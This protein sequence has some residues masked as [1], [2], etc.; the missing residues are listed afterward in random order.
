MNK[1]WAYLILLTFSVFLNHELKSQNNLITISSTQ[2][3]Q[4]TVCGPSQVFT[5]TL[6]NSTPFLIKEDTLRIKMPSGIHYQSGSVTVAK[7]YNVSVPDFPVFTFPD[8]PSL[9]SVQIT[10]KAS[11]GCDALAYQAS[12]G[13]I[14]NTIKVNYLANTIPGYD[15]LVTFIYTVSQPNI[16]IVSVTNQSYSGNIGDVFTRCIT[17]TNGGFG[18]LGQFTLTDTHGSGVQITGVSLGQW[19]HSGSMETIVLNGSNFVKIGNGDSLFENGESITVCE[20]IKVTNCD[21]VASAF[22]AYWGCGG[23]NCQS[24][25]SSA[26]VVFPNLTPNLVITANG[27]NLNAPLNACFSQP[28]QQVLKIVNTGLG[29]AMNVQLAIFESSTTGYQ[30][31]LGTQLDTSSF[32]LQNGFSGL[33]SPVYPTG[34]KATNA[35]SCM[36]NPQGEV[37]LNIPPINPGDTLYLKWNTYSC[38]WNNCKHIGY[39]AIEGWNY[40]GS[41]ENICQTSYIIPETVG[42]A[43][44]DIYQQLDN[45]GSPSTLTNGQTGTFDFVFSTYA[46]SYPVG[47]GANWTYVFTLPPC[48]SYSGNLKIINFDGIRT[49][50]PSSVIVT[51]DSVI[52]VFNGKFPWNA[53]EGNITINLSA[54]CGGCGGG[55]GSVSLNSY[56]ISDTLASCRSVIGVSCQST[57]VSVICPLP[58]PQGMSFSYFEMKRSSYGLPDNEP[59]GGNGIPDP[60]PATLD[61]TKIR[62]DIAMFGD[63]ITDS[64]NGK[65]ITS[66]SYPSWQYCYANSS[67]TNGNYLSYLDDSLIVYRAGIAAVTCTNFAPT[68]TNAGTTRNF[69]F[70]LSISTL[71]ACFPIGFK[72]LNNDSLVFKPRYKVITNTGGPLL[73]CYSTNQYF[74]SD[75]PNPTLPANIF[76]CGNY[77]GDCA[78][79]GYYFD[80][81][82]QDKFSVTSCNNVTVSQRYYLSIGP[83]CTNYNG[84]NL[85]AYEYRNWAHIKILEAVVP[86][87]YSFVSAEF[88]QERTAGTTATNI[89]PWIPITPVNPNSN[90][91]TFDVEQYFQGYGG[92]LPLPDDGF[93]GY[94]NVTLE[95]SC[96]VIPTLYEPVIYNFTFSTDSTDFLSG[97]GSAPTFLS[98]NPDSITYISPVLL[99]Q[100]TLPSILATNNTATWDVSLGNTSGSSNALNGWL[101]GPQI[102]GVSIIQVY[103]L[104]NHVI[105]PSTGG[106]YQIG[107]VKAGTVR[108]FSLTAAY[109][110]CEQDSIIVYAG[111]NCASGYPASLSSYACKPQEITLKLSPLVP[112]LLVNAIGPSGTIQ[113]CDTAVYNVEGTNVQLGTAYQ[114]LL[115]ASLPVGVTIVPGSSRFSF[116]V[117]GPYV[118]IAD[119]LSAGGTRWNWNLSAINTFTDTNGLK[120]ILNP[121]LDSFKLS[122]KVITNCDYTSGSSI[123]FNLQ[124]TSTC[125]ISTGN[126]QFQ[127]TQLGITGATAT[128]STT[129][130]LNTNYISPC[131]ANSSMKISVINKGPMVFGANDSVVLEIPAGISFVP[132]S[133]SGL[134]NYPVNGVPVQFS[135]N[136]KNYVSWKIPAGVAAGDSTLFSFDYHG[137]VSKLSCDVSAFNSYSTS[138]KNITCV[139]S[140][141]NCGISVITGDTSLSVF[142]YKAYLSLS[143]GSG[144]SVPNPPAGEKIILNFDITNAG[145]SILQGA[146]SI[147]KFYNDVNGNGVYDPGDFFLTQDTLLV[148]N[149]SKVSSADTFNVP[150]GKGCSIIA[151]VDTSFNHCVCYLSQILIKPSYQDAGRDTGVCSGSAIDLG[152]P[153][154][155]G[156]TYNWMPLTGLNSGILSNPVLTTSNTS[157]QVDSILYLVRTNRIGCISNDSV[158]VKTFPLPTLTIAGLTN[159]SCLGQ[160]TGS[161]VAD[162]SG[163]TGNYS[164][165]WNTLPVQTTGTALN[166]TAGSYTCT[167]TDGKGCSAS[168]AVNITQPVAALVASDSASVNLLC[169]GTDNGSASIAVSGGNGNYSFSWNTLPVQ[170]S[171][172]ALNLAAGTYTCTVTDGKGCSAT[173]A[174]AISQPTALLTSILSF[175]NVTCAGDNNGSATA[176]ASGSNGPYGYT[177]SNGSSGPGISAVGVG[178]YTLTVTDA[179]GCTNSTSVSI[180]S[181]GPNVSILGKTNPCQGKMSG[182]ITIQATGIS[183]LS[184]HWNNGIGGLTTL[185]NLDSGYYSVTVTDLNGCTA[186]TSVN[187]LLLPDPPAHAGTSQTISLGHS[188]QLTAAGGLSYLWAPPYSLND[189]T[190]P[191][192]VASPLQTTIYR[193]TVTDMNDCSATDSVLI[194]V[195]NCDLSEWYVPSAFSPNGDGR[196]DI[197]YVRG[198]SVC[199]SNIEF[200]VY[201]RWGELVFFTS[202]MS[203]GWDGN[204]NGK[205]AETAAFIYYL[206]VHL[207]NGQTIQKKGNLTLLR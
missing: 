21:S 33:P 41:Y 159:V 181:T 141:K 194:T 90:T 167:V 14:E 23:Q 124:G 109:T 64:F 27:G 28:S 4:M 75:V 18:A 173:T 132:G 68:I 97:P 155:N 118:S 114:L 1:G 131:A 6:Y 185:S 195:V 127:S 53:Q 3:V 152:Y 47:P 81:Y 190:L 36:T 182:S 172:T 191:D 171:P 88:N 50:N 180:T 72:Y 66:L 9:T 108:N 99:L 163:G 83:C 128:Y 149:N 96:Q 44:S 57:S 61:F 176:N 10:F 193:V 35:Y 206:T 183:S 113:L 184:Y 200:S 45:N 202:N 164:Y 175:A 111:W 170:T 165:L 55:T 162:A 93:L 189:S 70:D 151:I 188:I 117:A 84:G 110:S 2:P 204:F 94:F 119:P 161:S 39:N 138:A 74:L 129:I 80:N 154:V 160:N 126:E 133:F 5:V 60:P 16:S 198:Q 19:N 122:F 38:T 135:L 106:I 20:T 49:L 196:N 78:V 76:Q 134:H 54:N 31:I 116:P 85:F 192:P 24:S 77:N 58:C 120:G 142:T 186:S 13:L 22:E 174:I 79:A 102:S 42:R 59:G 146:N 169:N 92:T 207:I 144:I 143:N 82:G 166:L 26:N 43:Y 11:A 87:G 12:G 69:N 123:G 89:S 101:S 177:W 91:L 37:F 140:G 130:H 56:Y 125:G 148:P 139:T 153:A 115:T 7:E 201:D 48:L 156:Y 98:E 203:S 52:A 105:I 32:S 67:I 63:T 157:N 40:S 34:S 104:D 197:L 25:A 199:L 103:D 107:T 15:S 112:D 158:Q 17:I 73:S 178:S 46:F 62:T 29:K 8:L 71:G 179:N 137:D 30:T 205:P 150:A 121:A 145:Q 51:G 147:I 136:G 65:V 95:P 100:S 86:T 187:L 168:T